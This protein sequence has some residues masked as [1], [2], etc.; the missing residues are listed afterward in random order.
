[1]VMVGMEQLVAAV[2]RGRIHAHTESGLSRA[3]II[4]PGRGH[5]GQVIDP[6]GAE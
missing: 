6:P 4:D 2:L 3:M 1:M 5:E